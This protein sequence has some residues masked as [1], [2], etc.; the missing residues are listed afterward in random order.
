MTSVLKGGNT[1]ENNISNSSLKDVEQGA[2]E[3][4]LS[5]YMLDV[6]RSRRKQLLSV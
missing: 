2:L 4:E 3:A 6:E 5:T 1:A